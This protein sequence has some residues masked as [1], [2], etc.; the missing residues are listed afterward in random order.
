MSFLAPSDF[1]G[2]KAVSTNEFTEDPVQAYIDKWEPQ[3]LR[4]LLGIDLYDEFVAD[5]DT[6]PNITPASVP[7]DPKFTVIFNA[8]SFDDDS[9]IRVSQGMKEMLKLMIYFDYVRDNNVELSIT[10]A[11]KGTYSNSEIARILETRAIENW[12][13]GIE[14]YK[15]IQWY[16]D[17]NPVPYDYDLEN[18]QPKD[19]IS[20]L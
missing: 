8:F 4:E 5:L 12:N 3:Y 16:I 19:T 15:N 20:W 7:A 1:T 14:T 11:T 2:I 18:M 17:D 6:A 9:I 13:L 10:G